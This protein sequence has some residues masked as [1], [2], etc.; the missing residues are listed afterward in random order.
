MIFDKIKAIRE[1]LNL[2]QGEI[3]AETG[4]SQRDISFIER[5]EKKFIPTEY[6]QFLNRKRIPLDKLF[7]DNVSLRDFINLLKFEKPYSLVPVE[8]NILEEPQPLFRKTKQDVVKIPVVDISL[9]AGLNGFINSSNIDIENYFTLP[10]S[11][12]KRGATYVCGRARGE[13]MSPTIFDGNWVILRLLDRSEWLE[14]TNEHVY[15]ITDVNDRSFLKRV[16]NRFSKGYIVCTSDNLDKVNYQ[17]FNLNAEE[18]C[19]IWHAEF[20]ISAKMPNINST[21]FDRLRDLED[22]MSEVMN[23]IR[24]IDK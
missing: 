19:S 3:A 15:A 14:M 17:N 2:T 4:L 24:R 18:I 13:S 23:M 10:V 5:G 20:N 12:V 16:K 1:E 6:I 8:H 9:A 7:D 11:L 22:Q 21:Y